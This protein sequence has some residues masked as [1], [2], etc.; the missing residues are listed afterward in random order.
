MKPHKWT[1][2]TLFPEEAS[3][4]FRITL[5]LN[6][7]SQVIGYHATAYIGRRSMSDSEIVGWSNYTAN[8]MAETLRKLLEIVNETS[9]H[10]GLDTEGLEIVGNAAPF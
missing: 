1:S 3:A 7:E 9:E 2:Q 10:H 8:G 5:S 4:Q 6:Q